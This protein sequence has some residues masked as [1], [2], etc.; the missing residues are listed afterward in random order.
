M[1]CR[2]LSRTAFQQHGSRTGDV[3]GGGGGESDALARR[4]PSPDVGEV[5]GSSPSRHY[6]GAAFHSMVRAWILGSPPEDDDRV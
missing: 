4:T 3:V 2:I 1:T 6:S 5:G